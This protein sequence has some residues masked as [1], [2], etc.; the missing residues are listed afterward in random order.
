MPAWYLSSPTFHYPYYPVMIYMYIVICMILYSYYIRIMV[1]FVRSFSDGTLN[2]SGVRFG[3][4][5]IYNIGKIELYHCLALSLF[6]PSS[7]API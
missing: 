1:L 6:L 7:F 5:E 4:A 3:S 2:P